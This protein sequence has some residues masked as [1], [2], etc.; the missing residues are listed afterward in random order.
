MK[1]DL[2]SARIITVREL[3]RDT[4]AVLREINESGEPAIVSKHGRL[5]AMLAPLDGAKL[6]L[7]ALQ[8]ASSALPDPDMIDDEMYGSSRPLSEVKDS[9]RPGG[10][11]TE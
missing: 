11:G 9:L 8:S 10:K 2:G 1:V 7:V 4:A 6:E 5:V 3:S